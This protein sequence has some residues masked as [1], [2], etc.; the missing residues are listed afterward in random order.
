M[1]QRSFEYLL[2]TGIALIKQFENRNASSRIYVR[3]L[4]IYASSEFPLKVVVRILVNFP[5]KG[6][7][8]FSV[9]FRR[10]QHERNLQNYSNFL[11]QMSTYL[12]LSQ[13]NQ[14]H[15]QS[16]SMLKINFDSFLSIFKLDI[17]I[18]NGN[19]SND[20]LYVYNWII[21]TFNARN[22]KKKRFIFND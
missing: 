4:C 18:S 17:E 3:S 10:P 1:I 20:L 22:F 13:S 16:F 7:Q 8:K 9:S 6:D 12:Y 14:I 15:N 2:Q 11:S 19:R 5:S 21:S